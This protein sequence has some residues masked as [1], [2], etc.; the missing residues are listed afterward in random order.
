[1][2]TG[3]SA[4]GGAHVAIWLLRFLG[5]SAFGDPPFRWG[6]LGALLM[7]F[8]TYGYT[9][10]VVPRLPE[11][12]PLHY[13]GAGVVDLI[14]RPDELFRLP[15][16]GTIVLVANLALGIFLHARERPAAHVLLWTGAAVQ[17]V[18]AA[19]VWVLV[20]RAAG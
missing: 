11:L 16:I 1:M 18:L 3:L 9:W 17:A 8:A 10:T 13:N 14:G 15:V 19:G 4:R 12:M 5:S 7:N 20:D 6:A 2:H